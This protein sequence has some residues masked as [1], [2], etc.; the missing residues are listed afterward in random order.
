MVDSLKM[1]FGKLIFFLSFLLLTYP[2]IK[3]KRH[4]W[5]RKPA[6]WSQL[7]ATTDIKLDWGVLMKSPSGWPLCADESIDNEPHIHQ[8][9][10]T[11][12]YIRDIL[13][14]FYEEKRLPKSDVMQILKSIDQLF[15]KLP[16]LINITIP[17]N[18]HVTVCGDIHGQFYDLIN[19]FHLGGLPSLTNIYIFNGDLVDRGVYSFETILFLFTLKLFSPNAIHFNRGNHETELMNARYGFRDEILSKYDNE[20]YELFQKTFHKFPLASV[21]ENKI[22]VVHG[23][24]GEKLLSLD[25]IASI[26]RFTTMGLNSSVNNIDVMSFLW[27][28]PRD[29]KGLRRSTRGAGYHFGPDITAKF[30]EANNLDLLIRSHEVAENGFYKQHNGKCVTVFSAPNYCDQGHN[31]GAFIR[32]EKDLIPKYV[33]FKAVSNPN[34]ERKKTKPIFILLYLFLAN[35]SGLIRPIMA[36]SRYYP[37]KKSDSIYNLGDSSRCETEE[38]VRIIY[39]VSSLNADEVST[40]SSGIPP[41]SIRLLFLIRVACNKTIAAENKVY[42]LEALRKRDACMSPHKGICERVIMRLNK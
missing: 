14:S 38:I 13:T 24:L 39:L 7:K 29:I 2:L 12:S 5:I 35:F 25:E 30:L 27:S 42:E 6:K 41:V 18:G 19:I 34:Y 1:M 31:L 17:S 15:I 21:I 22:F 16:T 37:L 4:N 32:F 11:D 8:K 40:G 33:Q 36:K 20:V 10:I 26:D 28:D 3:T 23:G 9:Y